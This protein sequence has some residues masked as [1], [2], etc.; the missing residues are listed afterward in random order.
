VRGEL[1]AYGSSP[2]SLLG[3]PDVHLCCQILIDLLHLRGERLK[4]FGVLRREID[5]LAGVAFHVIKREIDQF[6]VSHGFDVGVGD[7]DELW[8]FPAV[9]FGEEFPL[10]VAHGVALIGDGVVRR[11]TEESSKQLPKK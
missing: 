9:K 11:A 8:K 3:G 4:H 7:V 6:S 2:A 1:G 10:A 5:R